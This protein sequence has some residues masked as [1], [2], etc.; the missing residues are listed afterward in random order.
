M[1]SADKIIDIETLPAP[2]LPP[3]PSKNEKWDREYAAFLEMLPDLLQTHRDKYVAV[4]EG[5][6]VE[7]G[8]DKIAVEGFG[9]ARHRVPT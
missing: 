2:V 7:S 9:G 6:V 3:R 4:H 8:D 5:R 1:S